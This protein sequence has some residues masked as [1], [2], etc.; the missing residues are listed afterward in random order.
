[1][2]L[3]E[4]IDYI[5]FHSTDSVRL[6]HPPESCGRGFFLK[7]GDLYIHRMQTIDPETGERSIPHLSLWVWVDKR[8]GWTRTSVESGFIHPTEGLEA[9]RLTLDDK[10]MPKW[11]IKGN[12][13]WNKLYD[14]ELRDK[15]R[16][17]KAAEAA[18]DEEVGMLPTR[19]AT[20]S[21]RHSRQAS[22]APV[23]SRRSRSHGRESCGEVIPATPPPY[24]RRRRITERVVESI[25]LNPPIRVGSNTVGKS[26]PIV[27]ACASHQSLPHF[28]KTS[29]NLLPNVVESQAVRQV[30]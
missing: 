21:D 3:K 17:R 18:L 30:A 26:L 19:I 7:D 29:A 24:E 9:I 28:Q 20:S 16:K 8:G 1:M 4:C 13:K 5:V 23:S 12:S 2:Y 22:V 25:M 10:L 27:P 11:M 14:Q 15:A 6:D